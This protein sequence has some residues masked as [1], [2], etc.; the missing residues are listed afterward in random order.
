MA[1]AVTH[2]PA[3][4]HKAQWDGAEVT[5]ASKAQML[6]VTRQFEIK[7]M[8]CKAHKSRCL[9]IKDDIIFSL[10]FSIFPSLSLFLFEH[11]ATGSVSER[12]SKPDRC[13]G[14][15]KLMEEQRM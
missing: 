9:Q 12:D 4:T 15:S 11:F 2:L 3:P 14:G 5:R 8:S 10:L 6:I 13:Q 1:C 7:N